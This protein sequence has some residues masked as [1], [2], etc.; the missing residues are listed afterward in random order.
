MPGRQKTVDLLFPVGGLH[1]GAAHQMQPPY[2]TPD[3][4]NVRATE[5]LQGR[6]RGGSRPGLRQAYPVQLG[7]T[8]VLGETQITAGVEVVVEDEI[9][10]VGSITY[11]TGKAVPLTAI[12][13]EATWLVDGTPLGDDLPNLHNGN[14][15]TNADAAALSTTRGIRLDYSAG[16]ENLGRHRKLVIYVNSS[17]SGGGPLF[18]A[19]YTNATTI[20]FGVALS[21]MITTTGEQELT[22]DIPGWWT[23]ILQ[24][25]LADLGSGAFALRI[26]VGW[27]TNL[28]TE[29]CE[30]LMAGQNDEPEWTVT[31]TSI[32]AASGNPFSAVTAATDEIVWLSGANIGETRSLATKP[33]NNTITWTEALPNTPLDGDTF[34]I[35][36]SHDWTNTTTSI[37]APTASLFSSVQAGD[38]IRFLSGPTTANHKQQRRITATDT[39]TDIFWTPALDAVPAED[40]LFDI[41]RTSNKVRMLAGVTAAPESGSRIW[42]ANFWAYDAG[43]LDAHGWQQPQWGDTVSALEIDDEVGL[44]VTPYDPTGPQYW[45]NVVRTRSGFKQALPNYE[46]ADAAMPYRIG[47]WIVPFQGVPAGTNDPGPMFRGTYYLYVQMD[48]EGGYSPYDH[49]VVLEMHFYAATA[50]MDYWTMKLTQWKRD[51]G[52][53]YARA[54]IFEQTAVSPDAEPP[55]VGLM[56]LQVD[57]IDGTNTNFQGFWRGGE[58]T[59]TAQVN[60]ATGGEAGLTMGTAYRDIGFGMKPNLVEATGVTYRCAASFFYFS[61]YD[62]DVANETTTREILV[63][64][65]GGAVYRENVAG[66]LTDIGGNLTLAS[67]HVLSAA[68]WGQKLYIADYDEPTEIE[69]GDAGAVTGDPGPYLLDD[70]G[71]ASWN[72]VVGGASGYYDYVAIITSATGDLTADSY[73]V[74]G[75]HD[76]NG[77]TLTGADGD[78]DPVNY[79]I[80][81]GLKVFDP[82]GNSLSLWHA[83]AGTAPHECTMIVRYMDTFILAGNPLEP[84]V[85]Y[86]PAMGNPYDFDYGQD[87]DDPTKAASGTAS[88][89]GTVGG[90]ITALLSVSKDYAVVACRSSLWLMA[91]HPGYGGL[92]QN[93]SYSIGVLGQFAWCRTPTI[94]VVFLSLD[95]LYLLPSEGNRDPVPLSRDALP[96]SLRGFGLLNYDILMA[97]DTHK[98]GINLY[99]TNKAGGRSMHYWVSLQNGENG[100]QAGFWPVELNV[101]H[102]PTACFF[103]GAENLMAAGVLVGC[104]DGFIR[105]HDDHQGNDSGHMISSHV[106]FGPIRLGGSTHTEGKLR[107]LIGVLG[108]SSGDVDWSVMTADTHEQVLSADS[109]ASGTFSAGLSKILHP[110]RAGAS[111]L[112]K[113]ENADSNKAWA[114]ERLT[115]KIERLGIQKLV[116]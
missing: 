103:H 2:T 57:Y 79:R 30:V 21:C 20:D 31:T 92:I 111:M 53:R 88:D 5:T 45:L 115:I 65:A 17:T 22:F 38:T 50:G 54:V 98:D 82:S 101:D 37:I 10:P 116:T 41:I 104:A 113:L 89:A 69:T 26:T 91:G 18:I 70:G 80:A 81:R 13:G 85:W 15:D 107:E 99:A 100:W 42:A 36:T 8:G 102:Q 39:D 29:I 4:L 77:L 76:T 106:T 58:P 34:K 12:L 25:P 35:V 67:G 32:A 94:G 6:L 74:G 84:H 28:T 108:Q 96:R 68:Q 51:S 75:V 90:P 55:S 112:L 1:K 110:E 66:G 52:D 63:A 61:Y 16:R 78:G 62:A 97:Y 27:M 3:C 49:G 71:V 72:A 109:V 24:S 43:D 44:V 23:A 105:V 83:T 48:S 93:I 95:G 11:D 86:M 60:S 14:Y 87:Y 9:G 40:D 64:S 46:V 47:L 59:E 7:L 33:D 73:G 19:P 114:L 56:E